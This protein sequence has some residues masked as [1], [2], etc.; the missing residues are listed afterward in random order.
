MNMNDHTNSQEQKFFTKKLIEATIRLVVLILLIGW[1]FA[2]LQPFT[3]IVAWGMILAI[4]MFPLYEFLLKKLN[5]KRKLASTIV[6]IILLAVIFTP[7]TFITKSMVKNIGIV[8][9][10]L[11][12]NKLLIPPPDQS[13]KNWPVIGNWTYN[14][15][16][17][18]SGHL[19]IVIADNSAQIKTV[20][21][22]VFDNITSAG[23]G[24]LQFI[25]SIIISGILLSYSDQGKRAADDIGIRLIGVKGKEFIQDAIVTI[26]NVA[27]GILGVAFL[28]SVLFGLGLMLAGVPFVGIWSVIC[29]ILA[30]IQIGLAPLIIPISVYMFMTG[31]VVTASLLTIWMVFISLADNVIKPIVMGRKAPVPTL[32]IFL[33]AIGGFMLNGIIGLFI[34]AVVLSLGYKLFQWWLKMGDMSE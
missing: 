31:D 8:K 13:V 18:T 23:F 33:G 29:L 14:F 2:I 9:E 25:L 27:R 11:A 17:K 5:G 6:T 21:L 4:A 15:W 28:Q 3:I 1:C 7:A 20:G 16:Y 19:D 34:G 12:E 24:F 22:W 26:R 10:Q 32:V 30:I